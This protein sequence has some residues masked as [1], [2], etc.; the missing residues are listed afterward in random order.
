[1][2]CYKVK[3]QFIICITLILTLLAGQASA[4]CG[5]W[6]VRY[7]DNTDFL[8]DPVFDEAVASSTGNS[9]T[10]KADTSEE[11]QTD[12]DTKTDD[13]SAASEEKAAVPDLNGKWYVEIESA[14]STA[15]KTVDLIL[16]QTEERLQGYG[17][18][19]DSGS[20][21][22]ATATGSVSADSVSLDIKMNQGKEELKLEMAIVESS[23]Q[24]SYNLYVEEGLAESGN[25]TASRSNL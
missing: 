12:A 24:G 5:K 8:E 9:S 22:P 20:E 11:A 13:S 2:R 6:V 19:Q 1:M 3:A 7:V 10:T 4:G 23:M 17:T 14:N 15:A 21:T 25:A 16:I 18:L